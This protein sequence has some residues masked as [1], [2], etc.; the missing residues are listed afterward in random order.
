MRQEEVVFDWYLLILVMVVA[1]S[2]CLKTLLMP[3]GLVVYEEA[4]AEKNWDFSDPAEYTYNDTLINLS[5]GKAVLIPATTEEISALEETTEIA[6]ASATLRNADGD[7]EGDE[8]DDDEGESG[9]GSDK[10]AEV[11]S[12]DGEFANLHKADQVLDVTFDATLENGDIISLYL[13]QQ[14]NLQTEVRLCDAGTICGPPGYGSVVFNEDEG[15]YHITIAGLSSPALILAIDPPNHLK[16]DYLKATHTQLV[17]ETSTTTTYPT[18]AEIETT[19]FQPGDGHSW[20][21]FSASEALNG[22]AV[23]YQYS[24]DSGATWL[25]LPAGNDLSS[26]NSSRIRFKATLGSDGTGTP[27]L[28][29]MAISYTALTCGENWTVQY[30]ECRIG[31]TRLKDYT[32]SHQCGST[33]NLPPDNGTLVNCDY[34]ALHNCSG[35]F[36]SSLFSFTQGESET[37]IVDAVSETNTKLE[38]TPQGNTGEISVS[39]IEYNY[40]LKEETPETSSSTP[41]N[42]Y[43]NIEPAANTIDISSIKIIIYYTDEELA[44]ASIDEETAK[45]Y[46]YNETNHQWE[47]LNTTVNTAENFAS[48]SVTHFSFYGLFGGEEGSQGDEDSEGAG[49]S[50]SGGGSSSSSSGGGGGGGSSRR[51]PATLSTQSEEVVE[52]LLE[53]KEKSALTPQDELN[54]LAAEVHCSYVLE[55]SLPEE[56]SFLNQPSFQGEI[57]NKGNCE[58]PFLVL[59]LSPGLQ[60][61]I[62][63]SSSSLEALQ[64]GNQSTFTLIRKRQETSTFFS[65]LTSSTVFSHLRG[66][67]TIAGT[68]TVEGKAGQQTIFQK[69]LD[70]NIVVEGPLPAASFA[71]AGGGTIFLALLILTLFLAR[72][73]YKNR[74]KDKETEKRQN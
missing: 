31:N 49:S 37:V 24:T 22:Q 5:E 67:Q 74:K 65:F 59:S 71:L 60:N 11:Q 51:S 66:S 2:I 73:N 16:L 9:E 25:L 21:S 48:S 68:F 54:E 30:D 69:E 1:L 7:D 57:L 50:S 56:I 55:V 41:L 61:E 4:T 58:I 3:V 39:I 12:Q 10:T 62:A 14:N 52:P 6:V 42:R 44:A 46:Y 17:T 40:N 15:W 23:S 29:Q 63:L 72:K 33:V 32:D 19:D 20:G 18:A 70:L 28:E 64:E 53:T 47:E 45:I 38:I 34:C 36:S 27:A 13:L 43:V 26:V 35:S 8:E